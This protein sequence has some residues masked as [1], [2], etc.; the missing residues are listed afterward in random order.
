MSAPVLWHL[1]P[2]HYSEKV[3]WALAWKRVEHRRRTA[4]AAAHMLVAARLTRGRHRTFPVLELEGEAIGDS[5]AI[6]GALEAR[7][8]DPG[9]YPGDP[10]ERR[11]A[12]DLE[13]RFDEALGP[14]VRVLGWHHMRGDRERVGQI[15]ARELPQPLR[16][17][18][19]VRPAAT[20]FVR[21]FVALRYGARGAD[22]AA[23]AEERIASELDFLDSQ[24]EDRAHLVGDSFSVADLSAAALLYPLVL[25]LEGPKLPAPPASAEP[26]LNTLRTRPF[27]GWVQRIYAR[28]R[29]P[30][31]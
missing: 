29:K 3:R 31:E 27:W 2:S 21:Q 16:S 14:A 23:R 25:P 22:G 10:R 11:R 18:P 5:T 24:L 17:V 7:F 26:F 4:P 9:L 30:R 12:L 15:V 19:G 1:G 13:E 20:E 6:I 8:P 28:Y